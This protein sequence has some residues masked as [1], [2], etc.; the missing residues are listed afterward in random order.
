MNGP[1]VSPCTNT[2]SSHCARSSDAG[3]K[4]LLESTNGV[5]FLGTPH[6]GSG[7]ATLVSNLPQLLEGASTAAK[8]ASWLAGTPVI[9]TAAGLLAGFTK[10]FVDGSNQV[11]WLEAAGSD[12]RV[13]AESYRDIA[14]RSCISTRAYY[15]TQPLK[16]L[17]PKNLLWIVDA[18]NA[19][20]G[21]VGCRPVGVPYSD[22][23]EICKPLPERRFIS[24]EIEHWL[25]QQV[26][27]RERGKESPVLAGELTQ[28]CQTLIRRDASRFEQI[29][30]P[31]PR[32][33]DHI[34]SK[35][36]LRTD[37]SHKFRTCLLYTSPSPR[38]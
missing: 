10:W 13:L 28:I 12:L 17:I 1:P 6:S 26:L 11:E 27:N 30:S 14:M 9:G 3:E 25:V 32:H 16:H 38:D 34:P 36:Q 5:A 4:R 7:L 19:D 18:S 15:E 35:D 21:V 33:L 37:F 23:I 8:V 22:H 31:L 2:T 29:L 20:P 24:D